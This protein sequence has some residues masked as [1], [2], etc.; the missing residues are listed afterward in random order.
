LTKVSRNPVKSKK[1]GGEGRRA[2]GTEGEQQQQQQQ[3][4]RTGD[5]NETTAIG[6]KCVS[7]LDV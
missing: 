7:T 4:K 5:G 1:G 6:I 2:N 3:Q